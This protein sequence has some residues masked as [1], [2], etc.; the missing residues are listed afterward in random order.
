MPLLWREAEE[1]L[2]SSAFRL[3]LPRH[4]FSGQRLCPLH[5]STAGSQPAPRGCHTEHH[6][7]VGM[8]AQ[9][10]GGKKGEVNPLISY[11]LGSFPPTAEGVVPLWDPGRG[12]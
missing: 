5:H 10:M 3:L 7:L 1:G 11:P 12:L 4:N 6:S 2:E 8:G 9:V